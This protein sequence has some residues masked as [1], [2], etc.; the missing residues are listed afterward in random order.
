MNGSLFIKVLTGLVIF[1]ATAAIQIEK[2]KRMEP[3]LDDFRRTESIS[4][5]YTYK[6]YGRDVITWVDGKLLHCGVSY[7]GGNGSCYVALRG[8]PKNSRVE[9]SAASI[10]TDAGI[11]LIA[12]SIKFNGMEIYKES[13]EKALH[14]W[15]HYSLVQVTDL[16][17]VLMAVYIAILLLF[18]KARR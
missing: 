16:P 6:W 9:V 18:F 14:D 10:N 17:L 12:A 2:I 3:S 4:G 7:G 13:P 5:E 8:V 1:M 15:W 11:V